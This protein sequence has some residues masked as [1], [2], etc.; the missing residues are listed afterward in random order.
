MSLFEEL[1]E[2]K[3]GDKKILKSFKT[4]KSL[5]DVI[6][7]KSGKDFIMHNEIREKLLHIA[8]EFID[9]LGI[10]FVIHDLWLTGSLANYN[11]SKFSDIDLHIVVD[12]SQFDEEHLELYKDLF[13]INCSRKSN[14]MRFR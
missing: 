9:Y 6:F 1:I 8:N 5:S 4:K 7:E 12:F 10:D 11:W 3:D 14:L 2:D 13:K